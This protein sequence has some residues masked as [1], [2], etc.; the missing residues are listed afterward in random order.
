MRVK[1]RN[2]VLESQTGPVALCVHDSHGAED[3]GTHLLDFGFSHRQ[4]HPRSLVAASYCTNASA[5]EF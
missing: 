3:L 4:P 1:I 5:V 2:T